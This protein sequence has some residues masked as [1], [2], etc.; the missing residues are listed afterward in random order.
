MQPCDAV[1]RLHGRVGKERKLVHGLDRFCSHRRGGC[2]GLG[3]RRTR[4]RSLR[5]IAC[6]QRVRIEVLAGRLVPL[7]LER[8]PA[9]E[10]GPHAIG[11]H[12]HAFGYLDDVGDALHIL[13]VGGIEGYELG[14]KPGRPRDHRGEQSRQ[15]EVGG[16]NRGA[17]AF[18]R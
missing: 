6:E 3:E 13:R 1:H 12:C 4:L 11:N 10:R 8:A 16:V 9:L 7:H 2:C 18:R 14:A 5:S 17:V 15:L